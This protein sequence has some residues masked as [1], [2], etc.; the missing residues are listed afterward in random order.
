M[1]NTLHVYVQEEQWEF[2]YPSAIDGKESE[3]E[4]AIILDEHSF[5][6]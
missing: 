5:G 3:T 6:D 2:I 4:C 1:G